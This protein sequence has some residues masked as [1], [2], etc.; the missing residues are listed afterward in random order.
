MMTAEMMMTILKTL[1]Q[2]GDVRM[3]RLSR[4][5]E[6]RV[7]FIDFIGFDDN[8]CEKFRHF[9]M[10]ELIEQVE[11]IINEFGTGNSFY[12]EV[13]LDGIKFSFGYTSYDI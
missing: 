12:R 1:E 8:W 3:F 5:G 11:D 7:D 9:A 4:S 6:I 2:A 10:P 13:V